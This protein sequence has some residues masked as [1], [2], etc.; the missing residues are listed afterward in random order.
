[1][2]KFFLVKGDHTILGIDEIAGKA[3]AITTNGTFKI[4]D[5]PHSNTFLVNPTL[6]PISKIYELSPLNYREIY[7]FLQFSPLMAIKWYDS[8]FTTEELNILSKKYFIFT[9]G[10]SI[11]KIEY[12]EVIRILKYIQSLESINEFNLFEMVENGKLIKDWALNTFKG[13]SFELGFFILLNCMRNEMLENFIIEWKKADLYD[14][15]LRG[16]LNYIDDCFLEKGEKTRVKL[17][18]SKFI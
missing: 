2:A 14:I 7:D 17:V 11:A 9:K 8:P 3:H 16:F 15:D 13:T 1:M 12:Y 6:D 10:S 5:N 18:I 4:R